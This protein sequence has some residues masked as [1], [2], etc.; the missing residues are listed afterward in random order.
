[1]KN[2]SPHCNLFVYEDAQVGG[3]KVTKVENLHGKL[4]PAAGMPPGLV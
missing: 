4:G 1:M 3:R 2:A